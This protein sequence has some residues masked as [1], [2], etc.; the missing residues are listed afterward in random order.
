MAGGQRNVQGPAQKRCAV[1]LTVLNLR[2]PCQRREAYVNDNNKYKNG[3]P[4]G[5]DPAPDW[6]LPWWTNAVVWAA[7]LVLCFMFWCVVAWAIL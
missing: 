7:M 4:D 3:V 5:Y 6:P 1:F 2:P